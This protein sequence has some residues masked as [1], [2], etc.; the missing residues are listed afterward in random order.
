LPAC[1]DRD[2]QAAAE[3]KEDEPAPLVLVRLGKF[4][5]GAIS[6]RLAVSADL[7]AVQRADVPTEVTG[8]V[9]SV[10]HR[11][12][13]LVKKGEPVI[14][15]VDDPVR[16]QTEQKRILAA[17]A[18][19]KI[20]QAD[21]ARRESREIVKQKELL[22]AKALAEYERI[23]ALADDSAT[24]VFSREEAE[25]KRYAFAQAQI[26]HQTSVILT[27]KYDLEHSQAIESEK[28]A[29][30][31]RQT[32][33]YGLSQTT[34][35]SPIDGAISYLTVKPGETLTLGSKAFSV[36]DSSRL[37][38]RLQVPQKELGRLRAG[39]LVRISCEV[40]PD[41]EFDGVVEVINPVIDKAFGFVGLIVGVKD[42]SGFLR[43]GMFVSGEIILDTRQEALLVS[44]K[45]VSYDNEEPVIFLVRDA[46]AHRYVVKPGYST[47][48]QI[49][50]L[51]LV[52]ADGAAADPMD[53]ELVE[54]GHSNLKEGTKVSV[55]GAKAG[56]KTVS[57]NRDGA[58]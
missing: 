9:R 27:E 35:R 5:R 21:V 13:D 8:I 20:A 19:A 44:K 17:Q 1:R 34:L 51:G 52:G 53:G 45:A 43:P 47:K 40:F 56:V 16:L 30:V 41:K 42:N 10:L 49:E 15:L 6:S 39:L 25:V 11:E 54:I 2:G 12:G 23:R 18:K 29:T 48:T 22:L 38:A 33:E 57:R 14:Q 31:D 36:V 24:G 4:E 28:L 7:E 58:E 3:G 50:V 37:E 46:V 26:D 55:E 32:A